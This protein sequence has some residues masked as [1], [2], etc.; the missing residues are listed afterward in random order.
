MKKSQNIGRS[1]LH[2]AGVV[3]YVTCVSVFLGNA[4]KIFNNEENHFA[5]PVFMMLLLVISASVTGLLVLGKPVSLYLDGQK[6]E[7]WTFLFYTLAWL[8]VFL[9]VAGIVVAKI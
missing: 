9:V 3:V 8:G 4:A 6:K 7:A 2:S 1:F 5:I